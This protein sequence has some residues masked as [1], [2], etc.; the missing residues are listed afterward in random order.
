[1]SYRQVLPGIALVALGFAIFF[2]L[3]RSQQ[4]TAVDGP[5]RS[6]VVF[7]D[8]AQRLHWR[9]LDHDKSGWNAFL[10]RANGIFVCGF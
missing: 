2:M 8:P 1:M 3:L 9:V 7:Y 6:L 5:L 4:Y 10:G